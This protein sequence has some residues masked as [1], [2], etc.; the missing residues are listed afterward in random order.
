MLNNFQVY[1]IIIMQLPEQRKLRAKKSHKEKP[2]N[3]IWS[4]RLSGHRTKYLSI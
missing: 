2:T 3:T 1:M 4:V